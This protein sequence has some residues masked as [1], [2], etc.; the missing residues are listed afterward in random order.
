MEVSQYIRSELKNGGRLEMED[1]FFPVLK[2]QNLTEAEKGLDMLGAGDLIQFHSSPEPIVDSNG[3]MRDPSSFRTGEVYV[4]EQEKS[5]RNGVPFVEHFIKDFRGSTQQLYGGLEKYYSVLRAENIPISVGEKIRL[6][7]RAKLDRFDDLE[8]GKELIVSGFKDGRIQTQDIN[9]NSYNLPKNFAQFNHDYYT[10]SHPS[11]GRTVDHVILSQSLGSL[12]AIDSKGFYVGV[13]RGREGISVYTDDKAVLKEVVGLVRGEM[14]ATG[15]LKEG[16]K[17]EVLKKALEKLEVEKEKQDL[18]KEKEVKTSKEKEV[19]EKEKETEKVPVLSS[20]SLQEV[21]KKI[22]F[23]LDRKTEVKK[24]VEAEI[25]EVREALK[26]ETKDILEQERLK[27]GGKKI[28][29]DLAQKTRLE[30]AVEAE[31]V[32]QKAE[33]IPKPLEQNE[34]SFY[35][36]KM[37]E[38]KEEKEEKKIGLLAKLNA[39]KKQENPSNTSN[40]ESSMTKLQEIRKQNP[41][42]KNP[43][44]LI[45]KVKEFKKQKE[46]LNR[47]DPQTQIERSRALHQFTPNKNPDLPSNNRPSLMAKVREMNEKR[48]ISQPAPSL[49]RQ[50]SL[51]TLDKDKD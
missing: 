1:R 5:L 23:G 10:T 22:D 41:E 45:A 6:T 26:E 50:P 7:D 3:F 16:L 35:P 18:E 30:K 40:K 25:K 36:S 13:S 17:E 31:K 27:E 49:S 44:G 29:F 28:D 39:I 38:A 15:L 37:D 20:N 19:L 33:N 21:G 4:Y 12:P 11:Q 32:E 43:S 48:G 34:K 46:G 24:A 42:P 8:K 14:S 51:P 9:G 47:S 2:N